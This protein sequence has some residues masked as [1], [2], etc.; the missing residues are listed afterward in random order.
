MAS[1]PFRDQSSPSASLAG[2]QSPFHFVA[3]DEESESSSD[4][5]FNRV[6]NSP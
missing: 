2:N 4:E 5:N 1:K 3:K 6:T